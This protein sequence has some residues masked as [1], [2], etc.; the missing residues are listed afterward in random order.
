MY[1]LPT[2][3]FGVASFLEACPG[4]ANASKCS[5]LSIHSVLITMCT[6]FVVDSICTPSLRCLP[7]RLF[8]EQQYSNLLVRLTQQSLCCTAF[9]KSSILLKAAL[10]LMPLGVAGQQPLQEAP[11]RSTVDQEGRRMPDVKL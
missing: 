10:P 1:I 3:V 7:S 6:R 9:P 8:S 11:G 4:L 2:L 5:S